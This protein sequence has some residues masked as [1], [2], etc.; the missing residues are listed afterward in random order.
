MNTILVPTDFTAV[1]NHAAQYALALV[2]HLN[3]SVTLFHA[4]PIPTSFSDVPVPP[5]VFKELQKN[6]EEFLEKTKRELAPATPDN[7]VIYT[8]ARPGMFLTALNE[9]CR[10]TDPAAIVMSSHGRVG[11][12]RI[13]M[14]SETSAGV[15]RLAWPLIVVPRGAKFQEP[16]NI[17]IA[18]DLLKVQS[19]VPVSMIRNL[20]QTFNSKLFILHVHN[21]KTY[22]EEVIEGTSDLQEMLSDLHP[23]YHFIEGKDVTETILEFVANTGIDLLVA[24]PKKHNLLSGLFNKSQSKLMAKETIV[25][26]MAVHE[27]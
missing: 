2:A 13:I 25:P 9:Y 7:V 26:F 4:Y 11:M 17:A 27:K 1:A 12:E 6:A 14:G 16:K 10:E 21:K 23:S 18:C 20:V 24:F 3:M 8:H 22:S 15:T 19:T 5:E